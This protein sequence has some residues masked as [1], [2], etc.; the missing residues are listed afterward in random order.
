MKTGL[1]AFKAR[2]EALYSELVDSDVIDLVARMTLLLLILYSDRF[3]YVRIPMTVVCGFAFLFRTLYR[4]KTF[5]FLLTAV[6][7][8]GD[9][10]NWYIIDNH[11]YLMTYW[12]LALCCSLS[13]SDSRRAIFINA[14][15]LTAFCFGFA[16]L[17]KVISP[18]YL[19]GTAFHYLLLTDPRFAQI[20]KL[21]GG[22]TDQIYTYN[23]MVIGQF[24]ALE[25]IVPTITLQS[26]GGLLLLAK[27][28]TWWTITVEVILAIAFFWPES[29][30]FSEWRHPIL[31]TF[32]VTTYSNAPVVGF[33]WQLMIMGVAQCTETMKRTRFLYVLVF[34]LIQVFTMPWS[35]ILDVIK[36]VM[37]PIS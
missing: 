19:N 10:L 22:T 2:I 3:W 15:L 21:L 25:S 31:L 27:I 7:A 33:G 23:Q 11:K 8:W 9:T 4:S 13:L 30:R 28:I 6:M 18:D 36:I 5:W 12:C 1:S 37:K 32:A 26:P 14:K 16:V 29:S 20:G 34:F 17:W 24:V 35:N